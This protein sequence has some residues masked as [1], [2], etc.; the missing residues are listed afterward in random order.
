VRGTTTVKKVDTVLEEKHFTI[1]RQEGF[2][3]ER[4]LGTLQTKWFPPEGKEKTKKT[5]RK[6]DGRGE[7]LTEGGQDLGKGKK[8]AGRRGQKFP[9]KKFKE[10]NEPP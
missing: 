6:K 2:Q 9:A 5:I 7:K 8:Y 1:N 3:T 4:P 10:K